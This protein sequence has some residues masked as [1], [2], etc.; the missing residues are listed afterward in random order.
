MKDTVTV[1][2]DVS[3]TQTDMLKQA[4]QGNMLIKDNSDSIIA[5]VAYIQGI[6]EK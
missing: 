2:Q 5:N 3:Q 6:I 1:M 4:I